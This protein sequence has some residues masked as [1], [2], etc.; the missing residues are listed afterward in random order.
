[1]PKLPRVLVLLHHCPLHPNHVLLKDF[2]LIIPYRIQG[3]TGPATTRILVDQRRCTS[4]PSIYPSPLPSS[5][6]FMSS[7]QPLSKPMPHLSMSLL[8]PLGVRPQSQPVSSSLPSDPSFPVR[9]V[10]HYLPSIIW[11]FVPLP[12]PCSSPLTFSFA[13]PPTLLSTEPKPFP[14][15]GPR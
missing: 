3:R 8:S 13:L 5:L 4:S 10:L 9:L 7:T 11:I 12:T 6:S 2:C 1:M 14:H 15:F